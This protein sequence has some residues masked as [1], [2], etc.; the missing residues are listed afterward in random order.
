[1]TAD[2][3]L[4]NI[5]EILTQKME[6]NEVAVIESSVLSQLTRKQIY[7][8]DIIS[9]MKNPTAGELAKAYK[10]SKPSVTAIIE[11][12]ST[13]GYIDKVKS[14]E[15]RR[16]LHVH[17]TKKGGKIAELHDKIHQNICDYIEEALNKEEKKLFGKYLRKLAEKL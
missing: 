9:Q 1:M 4:K 11:K 5:I 12:L 7:Y 15:D 2:N 16:S 10:V 14:D 13:A 17:L 3:Q 6:E 8:L